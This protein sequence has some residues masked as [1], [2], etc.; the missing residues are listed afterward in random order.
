MGEKLPARPL[1]VL[2]SFLLIVLLIGSSEMLVNA[3]ELIFG[4][5]SVGISSKATFGGIVVSNFTSPPD[6]ENITQIHVYL[7]TGGTAAKA[8]IYSDNQGA[9]DMLL[10]E[11]SEVRVEGTA[12]E[13]VGLNVNF[14]GAPNTVYWIGILFV[15]AGTYFYTSG[16]EDKAIYSSFAPDATSVFNEATVYPKDNLSVY[17][18]YSPTS[19]SL[20]QGTSWLQ[21]ILLLTIGIGLVLAAIAVIIFR[22]IG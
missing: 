13:W 9:P 10:A 11:S 16:V 19:S 4:H 8:V 20:D 6:L 17:A 21:T 15:N 5:V 18:V 7:A 14:D 22:R 3:E 12:G 2:F 1:F